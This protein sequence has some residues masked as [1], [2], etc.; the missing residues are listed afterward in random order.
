MT[1]RSRRRYR[2]TRGLLAGRTFATEY[3]YRVALAV[4]Q[5][6]ASPRAKRTRGRAIRTPWEYE[7]LPP[8][9]RVDYDRALLVLR[10]KR[11]HPAWS[12]AKAVREA[13]TTRETALAYVGSAL[14][15]DARGRY[16]AKPR[17]GLLRRMTFL[18]P[19]GL[20][21]IDVTN[22][23]TA[24]TIG[25]YFAAVKRY[26]QTGDERSLRSFRGRSVRVG[27]VT[28]PF[29]TDPVVLHRLLAADV[30]A[31]ESIYQDVI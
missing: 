4:A 24:R 18:T 14:R 11:E 17:D 30:V 20:T 27:K 23:E 2:P 19:R 13:G 25:R 1:H 10:L 15:V 26:R 28:R 6:H 12:L 31:F 29:L 8:A 3:A 22:S 5:G 7:R 21:H 16:H 9:Q